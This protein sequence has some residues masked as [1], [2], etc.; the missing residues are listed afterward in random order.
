MGKNG[1]W[2]VLNATVG[3]R[4]APANTSLPWT[5]L[6]RSGL[7]ITVQPTGKIGIG[8]GNSTAAAADAAEEVLVEQLGG[9]WVSKEQFLQEG[10]RSTVSYGTMGEHATNLRKGARGPPL[11][12]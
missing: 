9:R 5:L 2:D 11:F 10:G 3:M 6:T 1:V 7:A 8:L 12:R 4:M